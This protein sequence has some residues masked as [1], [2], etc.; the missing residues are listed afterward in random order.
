MGSVVVTM[1]DLLRRLDVYSAQLTG[2]VL[3]LL[4][5]GILV[6]LIQV[7]RMFGGRRESTV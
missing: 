7:L 5:I 3:I 4:F 1:D 2:A 6:I